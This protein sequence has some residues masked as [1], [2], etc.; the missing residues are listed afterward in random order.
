LETAR[1]AMTKAKTAVVTA[2]EAKVR[3]ERVKVEAKEEATTRFR[4]AEE[5]YE[6]IMIVFSLFRF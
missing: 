2:E 4:K 3:F 1:K 5:A 6:V